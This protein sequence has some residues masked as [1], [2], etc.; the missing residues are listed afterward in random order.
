MPDIMT[1]INAALVDQ[2]KQQEVRLAKVIHDVN[3][4]TDE[5]VAE[6][7]AKVRET[8]RITAALAIHTGMSQVQVTEAAKPAAS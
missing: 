5:V 6:L 7:E 4:H 8:K 2:G 3:A 1:Q